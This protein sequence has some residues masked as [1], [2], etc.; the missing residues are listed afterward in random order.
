MFPRNFPGSILPALKC[1]SLKLN[2]LPLRRADKV[3]SK[4]RLR[5][6]TPAK[7]EQMENKKQRVFFRKSLAVK[8]WVSV[9]DRLPDFELN[10]LMYHEIETT[11]EGIYPYLEI[12]YLNNP[13][14]GGNFGDLE[15][16]DKEHN[17]LSSPSHW[18]PLP[19]FPKP[20]LNGKMNNDER[21]LG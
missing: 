21:I 18:M 7:L 2:K 19:N 20:F 17:R 1:G 12:G 8:G 4:Q 13:M 15:W 10:V 9:E 5:E 14:K 3:Y 16:M 6:L 11:D